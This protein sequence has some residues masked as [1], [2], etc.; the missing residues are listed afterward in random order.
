MQI[1]GESQL[2]ATKIRD[3]QITGIYFK[4]KIEKISEMKIDMN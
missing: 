1:S 3:N 4:I 2:D